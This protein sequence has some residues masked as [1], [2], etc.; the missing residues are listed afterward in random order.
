MTKQQFYLCLISFLI[1]GIKVLQDNIKILGLKLFVNPDLIENNSHFMSKQK[2][3][4]GRIP[5][6]TRIVVQNNL[7]LT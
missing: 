6:T 3:I 7:Y 2:N 1:Y 5:E 4:A